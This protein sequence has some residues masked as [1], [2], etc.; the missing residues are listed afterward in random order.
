MYSAEEISAAIDTIDNL[1]VIK[2]FLSFGINKK[3]FV[4]T[5][6]QQWIGDM[7]MD[8]PILEKGFTALLQIV[9]REAS[10]SV[11]DD[12]VAIQRLTS[13][14]DDTEDI[15]GYELV[16]VCEGLTVTDRMWKKLKK[17]KKEGF[18]FG[19]SRDQGALFMWLDEDFFY[20]GD[21]SEIIRKIW[22]FATGLSGDQ[23]GAI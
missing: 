2:T 23:H 14:A 4:A 18:G 19:T 8:R 3:V 16:F 20:S 13:L 10:I 12:Q 6:P 22:R 17:G 7:S 15:T 9:F 21:R 1:C 5:P 11:V